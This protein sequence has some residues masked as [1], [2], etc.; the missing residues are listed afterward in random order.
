MTFGCFVHI[1]R[2]DES[3]ETFIMVPISKQIFEYNENT[4]FELNMD[5]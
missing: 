4:I 2:Q 5:Y 3:E 1:Q